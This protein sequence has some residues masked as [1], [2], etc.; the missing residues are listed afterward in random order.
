MGSVAYNPPEGKDYKWYI[1]GKKTCQLG[2]YIAT[3]H[4]LII[5]GN[6]KQLLNQ[7]QW[8]NLQL[9]NFDLP[10]HPVTVAFLKVYRD[11]LQNH[12]GDSGG[13]LRMSPVSLVVTRGPP[14]W[15]VQRVSSTTLWPA[16]TTS[17]WPT[18]LAQPVRG[19]KPFSKTKLFKMGWAARIYSPKFHFIRRYRSL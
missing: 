4:L 16:G 18:A 2:D 15:H 13:T 7:H 11:S 10:P 9:Y 12:R 19:K 3:Y 1:S 14:W 5:K 8:H 6:Q 17:S